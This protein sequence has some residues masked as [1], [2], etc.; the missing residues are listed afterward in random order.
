M[1]RKIF[2]PFVIYVEMTSVTVLRESE[3]RSGG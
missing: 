1:E 2:T 3:W